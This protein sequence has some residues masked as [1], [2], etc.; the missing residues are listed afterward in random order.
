[1]DRY[2]ALLRGIN[3]GGKNKIP[4]AELKIAL[5]DLGY[6]SVQTY[7]QSGNVVF[8]AGGTA[9]TVE[10]E[11]EA[12]LPQRFRLDSATI[13]VLVLD[14]DRLAKIVDQAPEGFGTEPD[15][16][17]YDV[18]FLKGVT[19]DDVLPHVKVRPEVDAVWPYPDAFYY[20]RLIALR[21][22]TRLQSIASAPMYG[23]MTI[24]NWKT[25]TKL[26]AMVNDPS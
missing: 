16:Y 1:M 22:K 19:G 8:S 18:A 13:M 21:T 20:R 14:G 7:I 23:R 9:T 4:M 26:L 12:M 15:T 6:E 17:L 2:V 24:R 5:E 25:T 11:V 10:D 3:V